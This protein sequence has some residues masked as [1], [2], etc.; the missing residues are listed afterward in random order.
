M[1]EYAAPRLLNFGN[2]LLTNDNPRY[3]MGAN[4]VARQST[5]RFLNAA[6][7]SIRHRLPLG[8]QSRCRTSGRTGRPNAQGRPLV[9][10]APSALLRRATRH[11]GRLLPLPHPHRPGPAGA[12]PADA[13]HPSGGGLPAGQRPAHSAAHL[14]LRSRESHLSGLRPAVSAPVVCHHNHGFPLPG[15]RCGGKHH[16]RCHPAAGRK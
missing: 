16:G 7:I 1:Q 15:N 6:N 5:G 4:R 8:Q 2:F 11:S 14:E 9:R 10:A 12:G 13:A 3:M